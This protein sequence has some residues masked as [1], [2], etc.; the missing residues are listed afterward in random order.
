MTSDDS[1]RQFRCWVSA[2]I[3]YWFLGAV[4]ATCLFAVRLIRFGDI[5]S[6]IDTG[7]GVVIGVCAGYSLHY[8]RQW[9]KLYRND[10]WTRAHFDSAYRTNIRLLEDERHE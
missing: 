8:A 1:Y 10:P 4:F 3:A 6:V 2:R 5:D 9:V 7:I